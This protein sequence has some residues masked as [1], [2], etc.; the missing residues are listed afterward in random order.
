MIKNVIFDLDGT[1]LDTREGI[2]D[3][4]KY[5]ADVLGFKKLSNEELLAF[6]GPPIQQSFMDH[7]GC[8]REQAQ[9]AADIFREYYK[10][11]A[12]LRAEPYER[13]YDVCK[14]LQNHKIQMAVATYKREDYALTLLRH[15]QFDRY[16]RPMHGADNN[17]QMKKRDI[18]QLCMS[19][20]NALPENTVLIGDT[21][22]DAMGAVD[23]GIA[24]LAVT[25]G[26]G[27]QDKKELDFYKS[28]GV[29]DK[30]IEIAYILLCKKS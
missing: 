10:N 19:E 24:F 17:N 15:F 18:V 9:K 8:D 5:A 12:L 14:C 4:V 26:F 2:V 20:M 22:H 21:Y 16:C 11:V 3:S 29:A 23:A 28:I 7:Y 30:P 6:V 25:Y 27:F 1:L 13:I